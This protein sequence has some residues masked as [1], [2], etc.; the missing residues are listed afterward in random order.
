MENPAA[1]ESICL[2]VRF[3]E[4]RKIFCNQGKHYRCTAQGHWQPT[5]T[6]FDPP[7]T[8]DSIDDNS[9]DKAHGKEDGHERTASKILPE[10]EKFP[11]DIYSEHG[12]FDTKK[13]Y[14]PNM[15]DDVFVKKTYQ[16]KVGDDVSVKKTYQPNMGDD[17]SVKKTYQPNMGDDVSV[18]KKE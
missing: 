18:K 10:F 11:G 4:F 1:Q 2:S 5:T 12:T 7:P 3:R 6:P 16:P 13:T 15:G 8:E 14:Q 17:V 9:A